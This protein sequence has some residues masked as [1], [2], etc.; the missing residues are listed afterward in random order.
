MSNLISLLVP[1]I[2]AFISTYGCFKGIDVFSAMITGIKNGLKVILQI[3]PAL[4]TMLTG[5]Y[6]LRASGFIDLVTDLLTP[7][8]SL[9]GFPAETVPLML[10]R[11]FSGSAALAIGTEIM[12]KYGVDSIIGRTSAVM[13]GST[14]T[15]FYVLGIYFGTKSPGKLKAVILAAMIADLA[16]YLTASVTV[17]LF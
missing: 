14:E 7:V 16:S 17:K 4:I 2:I 15:T 8:L 9:I 6:M 12:G 5:I 1:C 11:P 3:L 13:L 10:V